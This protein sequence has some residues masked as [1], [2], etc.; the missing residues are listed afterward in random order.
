MLFQRQ[1]HGRNNERH[2]SDKVRH[3]YINALCVCSQGTQG[4]D[5]H[6]QW[7]VMGSSKLWERSYSLNMQA[8]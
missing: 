3:I 8:W 2:C 4:T 5:V 7:K 1:T 6:V